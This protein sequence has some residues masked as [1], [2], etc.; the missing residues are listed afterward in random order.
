[1]PQA[2]LPFVPGFADDPEKF[3]LTVLLTRIC[4]PYLAFM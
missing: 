2:L 1:M 3:D 4:F